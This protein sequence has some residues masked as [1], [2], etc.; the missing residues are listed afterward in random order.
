M[1]K[2]IDSSEVKK[3][4][5]ACEA[6]MGSSL[7]SVNALRKRFKKEKIE[8]VEVTHVA[9]HEIPSDAKLLIVHRGLMKVASKKAPQAVVLYFEQFFNDPIFDMVIDAFK[10]K[11]EII[12]NVE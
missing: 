7:M 12:S 4:Y 10:K 1:A 5:I 8:G 6:G 11:G 3:I 9:T 2:S